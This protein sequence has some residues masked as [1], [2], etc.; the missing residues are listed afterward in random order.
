MSEADPENPPLD[1]TLSSRSGFDGA[2]LH[3][4]VDEVRLP[5]GRVTTREVVEHPGRVA[6][7]G[8]T[9][10]GKVLLLR[11]SHHA[12][13]Q[14]VARVPAGTLEPGESARGVCA[15]GADG[16]NWLSRRS[17]DPAGVVLHL[18]W[19]HERAADDLPRGRTASLAV[20]TIDP[21]ELIRLTP[22]PLATFHAS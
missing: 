18:S 22:M 14:H 2:W 6:I 3:V 4:R 12:I 15:T 13:G 17:T 8:I 9:R 11:Q 7:V 10:D 21:D 19:L 16:G 1:E 20:V 5:T